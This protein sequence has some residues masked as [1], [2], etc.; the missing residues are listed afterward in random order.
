MVLGVVGALPA[1]YV[2]VGTRWEAVA[3]APLSKATRA[4]RAPCRPRAG[5]AV[6]AIDATSVKPI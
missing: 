6:H 3:V 2:V 4:S 5:V 1:G